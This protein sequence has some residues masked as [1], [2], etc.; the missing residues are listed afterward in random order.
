LR[1]ARRKLARTLVDLNT[2][3]LASARADLERARSLIQN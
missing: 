2:T 1:E 3:V